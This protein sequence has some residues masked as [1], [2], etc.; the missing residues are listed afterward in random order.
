MDEETGGETL[1][2]NV[3]F[4]VNQEASFNNLKGALTGMESALK[5]TLDIGVS[6]A[7]ATRFTGVKAH[8]SKINNFKFTALKGEITSIGSALVKI[9]SA[10]TIEVNLGGN[11]IE[12]LDSLYLK[13]GDS[14]THVE[15]FNINMKGMADNTAVHI[16]SQISAM[17]RLIAKM[18][19]VSRQKEAMHT[20]ANS[21]NAG[22]ASHISLGS[23]ASPTLLKTRGV[24]ATGADNFHAAL[25]NL[26][27][28]ANV[29]FLNLAKNIELTHKLS[30]S[31][32]GEFDKLGKSGKINGGKSAAQMESTLV[33]ELTHAYLDA[34]PNREAF[35]NKFEKEI[36]GNSTLQGLKGEVEK[37]YG[38]Y[39]HDRYAILEEVMDKAVEK[40]YTNQ[41]SFRT[42][43]SGTV[44]QAV[45][46][47]FSSLPQQRVFQSREDEDERKKHKDLVIAQMNA[48]KALMANF[49][50][51]KEKN[52][53]SN[54]IHGEPEF[55]TL[56]KT[57]KDAEDNLEN[58]RKALRA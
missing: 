22:T 58:N 48:K 23:N 46:A 16:N 32:L 21:A 13:M 15:S 41:D 5:C 30:A 50:A 38:D 51:Y 36:K 44:A 17:D 4:K 20:A 18:A 8:L 52:G 53:T 37:K 45:K 2:F 39:V 40:T 12:S 43:V 25:D 57:L 6:E 3:E 56:R 42:K 35:L 9:S 11:A 28:N 7:T 27:R 24:S 54:W 49:N 14:R 34:L 33:H 19:A 1:G 26:K 47:N 10:H 29:E 31:V 55:N